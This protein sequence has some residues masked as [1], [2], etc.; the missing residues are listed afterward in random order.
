MHDSMN[1]TEKNVVATEINLVSSNGA[2]SYLITS[3]T[4]TRRTQHASPEPL[5]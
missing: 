1:G 5:T 2:C 4:Q 3:L